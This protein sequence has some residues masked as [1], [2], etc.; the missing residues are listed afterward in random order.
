MPLPCPVGLVVE[1]INP[2]IAGARAEAEAGA[3]GEVKG[4]PPK[5]DKNQE[6][7]VQYVKNRL[8]GNRYY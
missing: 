7:I 6:K 1:G 2:N 3:R 8:Y 5:I 4:I